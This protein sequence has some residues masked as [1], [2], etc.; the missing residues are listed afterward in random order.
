MQSTITI[1]LEKVLN[2]ICWMKLKEGFSIPKPAPDE[3][4]IPRTSTVTKQPDPA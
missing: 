1:I 4:A 2:S 3:P